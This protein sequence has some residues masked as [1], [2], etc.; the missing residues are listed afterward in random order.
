MNGCWA[1]EHGDQ[2]EREL[3]D[4]GFV[5]DPRSQLDPSSSLTLQESCVLNKAMPE[6]RFLDSHWCVLKNQC[7]C[8]QTGLNQ[9]E[10][11][12]DNSH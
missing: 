4:Q 6:F 2:G 9:I 5:G 3:G 11:G 1:G 7:G 10:T 12:S 8:D